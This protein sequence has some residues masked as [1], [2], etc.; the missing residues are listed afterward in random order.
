[1]KK[2]FVT[3]IALLA[4]GFASA[5]SEV[6][7]KF[8]EGAKAVQEKNYAS[9]ITLFETVIDKGM[10]SEDSK[11]L[12]CVATAKK[13]L[14][15]C[16][17]GVGLSAASQKNYPK[18]IE[19]LTK[20][21]EIAELYGNT[22]AKQKAM[23]IL[24]KV[25]QVQGGEAFNAKDYATAASVFEKGYA[26]NPRNAEMALNLATSYCELG[27]YDEGMAIYEKICAMPADKYAAAIQKAND[28]KALYTNN[29]IASLQQANDFDGLIAMAEK[30]VASNPALAAKL[31]IEAY[32]SKKDYA[33]VIE[34]GEAAA[35]AQVN[36][37]EKSSIYFLVGAA[38]NTIY[39]ASENKDL[40]SRDKAIEALKK[41][42]AG[43][44]VE[45][46]KAALAELTKK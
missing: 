21:A 38:H 23:T 28:N 34:L 24:A 8:N 35:A 42:V 15:V 10:D 30:L 39:N 36:D 29:K 13:Y 3:M 17:Q 31:N 40:V 43:K 9:A 7:A 32:S 12:N 11:V 33:K 45:V 16:Y 20:A 19:Y 22:P 1:M 18:A 41:V 46:A 2:L 25:Y 6:I 4:V 37:E 27:K 26:A 5:Q 14:P 44:D